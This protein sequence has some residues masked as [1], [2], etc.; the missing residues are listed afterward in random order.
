MPLVTKVRRSDF[1]EVKAPGGRV[2]VAGARR[3]R[4][5]LIVRIARFV[6]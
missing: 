4:S 2:D 1:G 3:E 6:G 5:R